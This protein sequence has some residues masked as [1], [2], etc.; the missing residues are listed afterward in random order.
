M[1]AH[2]AL[3][4]GSKLMYPVG[5]NFNDGKGGG[6]A[7]GMMERAGHRYGGTW[8]YSDLFMSELPCDCPTG[9]VLMWGG[10][11]MA[12]HPGGR[13]AIHMAIVHLFN[14]HVCVAHDWTI[15]MMADWIKSIDPTMPIMLKAPAEQLELPELELEEVCA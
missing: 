8:I 10:N 6:C 13:L 3:L 5:G 4:A 12:P 14:W 1:Y 15:E 9:A 7:Y 2:E 11:R